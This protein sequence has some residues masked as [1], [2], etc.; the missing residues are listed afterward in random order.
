MWRISSLRWYVSLP[1]K[2]VF[3]YPRVGDF[4]RLSQDEIGLL[5]GAL[6]QRTHE[7]LHELGRARL[8]RVEFGDATVLDLAGL[9]NYSGAASKA[10]HPPKNVALRV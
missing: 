5:S 9:R 10:T 2:P 7:T 1:I 4:V 3:L 8:L 6:R